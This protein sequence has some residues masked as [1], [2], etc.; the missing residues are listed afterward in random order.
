MKI[1]INCDIEFDVPNEEFP[2][3]ATDDGVAKMADARINDIVRVTYENLPKLFGVEP[4]CID[5]LT[6]EASDR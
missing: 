1:H 4:T 3:W 5:V 2:S 6:V